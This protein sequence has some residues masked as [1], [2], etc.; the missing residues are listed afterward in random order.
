M[1]LFTDPKEG[2]VSFS[3]LD[4]Q[5]VKRSLNSD[6]MSTGKPVLTPLSCT[7]ELSKMAPS[8]TKEKCIKTEDSC[9]E[10]ER[11]YHQVNKA[12]FVSSAFVGEMS[13]Y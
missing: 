7:E 3:S 8:S 2:S 13:S 1:V 11:F 12:Q 6:N 10:P 9:R 5:E 4:D